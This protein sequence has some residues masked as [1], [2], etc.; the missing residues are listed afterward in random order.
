[1]KLRLNIDNI[2]RDM[3][4]YLIAMALVVFED[5]VRSVDAATF[6]ARFGRYGTQTL[7]EYTRPE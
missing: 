1:M 5:Y 2:Y 3:P 4:R 7:A 6:D